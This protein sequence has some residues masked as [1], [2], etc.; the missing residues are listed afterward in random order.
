MKGAY[1][2]A[3]ITVLLAGMAIAIWSGKKA[4]TPKPKPP[5]DAEE[6]PDVP[7]PPEPGDTAP[8]A[9][10]LADQAGEAEKKGELDRAIALYDKSLV[11]REDRDVA[12][13]RDRVRTSIAER[14][15]AFDAQRAEDEKKE[16]LAEAARLEGAGRLDEA[17]AKYEE[18]LK[19]G[20]DALAHEGIER[21][22]RK[23]EERKKADAERQVQEKFEGLVAEARALQTDGKFDEA[24]AKYGEALG[25]RDDAGIRAARD[26]AVRLGRMAGFRGKWGFAP[27]ADEL[28]EDDWPK[29][30][31]AGEL[32]LA[33]WGDRDDPDKDLEARRK[34]LETA[35]AALKALPTELK[36]HPT[37]LFLNGAQHF[38]V[39]MGIYD[40]FLARRDAIRDINEQEKMT[41]ETVPIYNNE[42]TM[43]NQRLK[44][45]REATDGH[46]A[47]CFFE[48]LSRA[49]RSDKKISDG[50]RQS[51][52]DV[53]QAIEPLTPFDDELRQWQA[54]RGIFRD[55]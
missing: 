21:I 17:V 50:G 14:Q 1:V 8:D 39:A 55:R 15:K 26:E 2:T 43:A 53:Y 31:A 28:S 46:F 20:D 13:A 47:T 9:R 10:A 36:K 3:A 44:A 30:V 23:I 40:D 37:F 12:A 27:R 22:K 18:R 42:L 11:L 16:V 5:V 51:L 4:P 48:A 34:D 41:R 6:Q 24:V 29:L 19:L 7:S 52:A 32:F 25:V 49:W 33:A 38:L 45:A 54:D 35:D